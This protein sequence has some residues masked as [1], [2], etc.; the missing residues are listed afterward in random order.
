MTSTPSSPAQA[1]YPRVLQTRAHTVGSSSKRGPTSLR[2]IKAFDFIGR[3]PNFF[4]LLLLLPSTVWFLVG[5]GEWIMETT[6]KDY[7][8]TTKGSIPPF[9]TKPQTVKRPSNSN[10][11]GSIYPRSPKIYPITPKSPIIIIYP[12]NP[13][14]PIIYPI[15]PIS[16]MIYPIIPIKPY[17]IPYKPPASSTHPSPPLRARNADE[18][19][20]LQGWG[21]VG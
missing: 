19:N 3:N 4:L 14:S 13:T 7:I 16:P 12:I 8:R 9:P 18:L 20:G 17:N 5:N 11:P 1:T 6:I 10:S 15:I 2:A 21:M